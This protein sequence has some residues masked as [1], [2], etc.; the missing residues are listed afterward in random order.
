VRSVRRESAAWATA[1][2][3]AVVLTGCVST[4]QI[5]ARTRLVN[6]RVLASQTTTTVARPDPNVTVGGLTLIHARTGTAIVV[7]L[8]NTSSSTLTDLPITVGV[9][10]RGGRELYLNRS[11]NLDY[12]DTHVAAIA[13][14]AVTTWVFTTNRRLTAAA[15]FATVGWP[16]LHPSL[17]NGLPRIDASSHGGARLSVTNASTIP[18]Y[19]LPVYVVAV[20]G[21]R[22]VAAGRAT[23]PHLGT[24]GTT[25]LSVSVLGSPRGAT[26][27]VIA[28]PTIFS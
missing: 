9:H 6:A 28:T 18:Q 8:R 16:Q 23:V 11:A 3:V 22:D 26:L 19:D 27:D 2:P 15:P 7:P 5:A 17:T 1:L 21:G 12:F 24:H 14:H 20:R 4:Q 13:P 25:T 10:A